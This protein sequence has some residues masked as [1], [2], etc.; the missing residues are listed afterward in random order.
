MRVGRGMEGRS[1]LYW[2]VVFFI[3]ALVAGFLGVPL[4]QLLHPQ[5]R[6]ARP[7]GVVFQSAHRLARDYVATCDPKAD[8]RAITGFAESFQSVPL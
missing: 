2:A 3:I 5:R 4:D 8:V 1:M 7:H 6:E